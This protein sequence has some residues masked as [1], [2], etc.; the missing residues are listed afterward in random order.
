MTGIQKSFLLFLFSKL[1]LAAGKGKKGSK[2]KNFGIFEISS[3]KTF[4]KC[5]IQ[6]E[7]G[8]LR[9]SLIK[10][11]HPREHASGVQNIFYLKS[12]RILDHWPWNPLAR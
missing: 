4:R 6:V 2:I 8:I 10:T 3:S 7:N 1:Q 5:V 9:N 11:G 12:Y